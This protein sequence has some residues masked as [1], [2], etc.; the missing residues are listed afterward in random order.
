[1]NFDGT[2]IDVQGDPRESYYSRYQKLG[3][4]WDEVANSIADEIAKSEKPILLLDIG[5]N[6]GLTTLY[7]AARCQGDSEPIDVHLFEPSPDTYFYLLKN[8]KPLIALTLNRIILHADQRME[9]LDL[10]CYQRA[11]G[12][13]L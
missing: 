6:I 9:F 12:H 3:I 2:E 11:Q 1:M 13:I 7:I 4:F 8:L 10:Q 5:A